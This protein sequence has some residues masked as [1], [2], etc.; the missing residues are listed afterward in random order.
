MKG[1][2]NSNIRSLYCKLFATDFGFHTDMAKGGGSAKTLVV[3]N[4]GKPHPVNGAGILPGER[5]AAANFW[6]I[7]GKFWEL[8]WIFRF[9]HFQLKT[10]FN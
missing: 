8:F 7:F 3:K 2:I 10:W 6:E 5:S 9:N 1:T 4:F